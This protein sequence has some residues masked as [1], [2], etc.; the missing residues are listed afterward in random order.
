M[1]KVQ[2]IIVARGYV[3]T[4]AGRHC[5]LQSFNGKVNTRSAYKGFN[6]LIQ[7]SA[8]DLMKKALVDMWKAGLYDIFLVYLTIHDEIDFGIPKAVNIIRRIPEIQNIMEHTFDLSVPMRVDPE[9]C[10]DWGHVAGPRKEKKDDD[11]KLTQK[12]ENLA[13]FLKRICREVKAV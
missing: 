10:V 9:I 13:Q 1:D 4:V 5:H 11:G 6:K 7:G 12:A 8:S 2:Q 3:K